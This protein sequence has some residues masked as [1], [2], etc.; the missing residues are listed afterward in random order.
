MDGFFETISTVEGGHENWNLQC[1]GSLEV[2]VAEHICK[3][4]SKET[5]SEVPIPRLN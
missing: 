2:R 5:V 4:I 1:E 3:R